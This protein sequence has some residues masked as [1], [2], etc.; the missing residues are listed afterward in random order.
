M[1]M[2]KTMLPVWKGLRHSRARR[3]H[4]GAAVAGVVCVSSLTLAGCD[5]DVWGTTVIP[6]EEGEI[7]AE[8]I[9]LEDAAAENE[10]RFVKPEFADKVRVLQDSTGLETARMFFSDSDSRSLVITDSTDAAMLR[11]ATIAI[12][13]HVPMVVM[14][15]AERGEILKLVDEFNTERIV[16]VGDVPLAAAHSENLT[17]IDDPGTDAALGRMTA[18]QYSKQEVE[19]PHDMVEAVANLDE[20]DRTELT[21]KWD[22]LPELSLIHI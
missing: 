14:T 15:P 16:T 6:S 3:T 9:N 5:E 10:N 11:G 2:K 4:V 1:L 18:F 8:K 22:T 17:V 12:S 21:A 20:N 19:S 13:Q 7:P